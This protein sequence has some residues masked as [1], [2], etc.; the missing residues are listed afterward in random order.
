M[1][2]RGSQKKKS[3]TPRRRGARDLKGYWL[4]SER[5]P[6]LSLDCAVTVRGL[7]SLKLRS[8]SE[9]RRICCP[10]VAAETP[11]P[12]PAPTVAPMAAPLPPPAIPP[13]MAP[14]AAPPPTLA[15][16]AF[17]RPLPDLDH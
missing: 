15:A 5:L 16:V 17:P 7:S 14:R 6:R 13:M 3:P 2:Y 8:A 10:L 9:P 4:L 12:A 11:V 1:L